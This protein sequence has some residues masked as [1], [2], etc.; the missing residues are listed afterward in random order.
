MGA[1]RLP[2]WRWLDGTDF[3]FD[4]LTWANGQGYGDEYMCLHDGSLH[5]CNN[6]DEYLYP[7]CNLY[8]G[9]S[10]L[11]TEQRVVIPNQICVCPICICDVSI[12]PSRSICN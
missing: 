9:C 6:R 1:D 3:N 2:N 10:D 7:I 8:E 11:T 12:C 4:I 5:E